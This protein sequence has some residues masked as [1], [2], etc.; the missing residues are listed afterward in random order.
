MKRAA[1]GLILGA[2]LF[3]GI[4]TARIN[5]DGGGGGVASA[6]VCLLSG[7]SGCT[8]TG[9]VQ[10]ASAG[11]TLRGTLGAD[12][13]NAATSYLKS[14]SGSGSI[15]RI[16]AGDILIGRQGDTPHSGYHSCSA[17]NMSATSDGSY[18]NC[19]YG[20]GMIQNKTQ[21]LAL[22]TAVLDTTTPT[23]A[24]IL[25]NCTSGTVCNYDPAITGR[26]AGDV[27][28]IVFIGT[29]GTVFTNSSTLAVTGSPLTRTDGT[30]RC[31][32]AS[33]KWRCR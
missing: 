11:G 19:V 14:V 7:G 4:A 12:N 31:V 21:A 8:M 29:A 5:G 27:M 6:L 32:L 10:L 2:V 23:S 9:D 20:E 26:Q 24:T 25:L 13:T 16:G 30:M 1:A 28:D 15:I 18:L 33:S 22:S 3:A 17:D